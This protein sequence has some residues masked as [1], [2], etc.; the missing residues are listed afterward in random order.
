MNL[1]KPYGHLLSSSTILGSGPNPGIFSLPVILC[2]ILGALLFTILII[3]G[4]QLHRWRAEHQ[5]EPSVQFSSVQL[6]S[7]VRLFVNPRMAARQ[8]SL[9]ITISRSSLRLMSIESVM[10]SSHPILLL[11][12]PQSL[13]PSESFPMSQLFS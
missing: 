2:I 9:S 12:P 4:I 3:L 8:A 6:L 10:P 11:L 7:R 5:G 13:P 1:I